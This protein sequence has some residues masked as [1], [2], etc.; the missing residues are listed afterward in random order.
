VNDRAGS[1]SEVWQHLLSESESQRATIAEELDNDLLQ[2]IA[3]LDARLSVLHRTISPDDEVARAA[4]KDADTMAEELRVSLRRAVLMLGTSRPLNDDLE[5]ALKDLCARAA[6]GSNLAYDIRIVSDEPVVSPS[7]SMVYRVC[8]EIIGIVMAAEGVRR[9]SVDVT[10]H[11]N[12]WVVRIAHDPGE[13]GTGVT[14][15]DHLAA[16]DRLR[17]YVD[18]FNGALAAYDGPE[19]ERVF[20]ALVPRFPTRGGS[21]R[22]AAV[23]AQVV[24]DT[25][26]IGVIIVD[27]AWTVVYVNRRAARDIAR[28]PAELAGMPLWDLPASWLDDQTAAAINDAM[29]SRQNRTVELDESRRFRRLQCSPSAFGMLITVEEAP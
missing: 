7:A 22:I 27:R 4:L 12:D 23:G 19:G 25:L 16:R 10:A 2:V 3:A 18:G 29:N 11:G 5:V 6:T 28:R 20:E 8:Q 15:M 24:V 14:A 26:G 1:S 9:V 17:N 13:A 21:W